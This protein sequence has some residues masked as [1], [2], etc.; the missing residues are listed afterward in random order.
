M[1]S[2]L[3]LQYKMKAIVVESDTMY[4]YKFDS[5][6]LKNLAIVSKHGWATSC[7]R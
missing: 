5:N 2:K 4:K 3:H 6:I 7:I 1:H